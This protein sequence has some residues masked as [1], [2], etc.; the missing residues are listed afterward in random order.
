MKPKQFLFYVKEKP[1][2]NREIKSP[3][4]VYERMK[5]L[6]NADQESLW[7]L[8]F[9]KGNK[10]IFN[11]CIFLG[12]FDRSDVDPR[13]IF[14]R[15]LTV[16]AVAFIMVHNHPSG[17]VAPSNDDK[18]TTEKIGK[19]ASIMGI[20]FLDHIIVGDNSFYSFKSDPL[21]ALLLS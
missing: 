10:E 1:L 8:G 5:N 9:D 19:I 16:G 12:G 14:K 20:D 4:M 3:E 6:S 15:L 7:I 17:R 11:E 21:D 13:V 2:S 18:A